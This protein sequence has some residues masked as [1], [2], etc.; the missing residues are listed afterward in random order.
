MCSILDESNVH[1]HHMWPFYNCQTTNMFE[2]IRLEF[3][4]N[5]ALCTL[6]YFFFI[7]VVKRIIILCGFPSC[8]ESRWARFIVVKVHWIWFY[9]LG[10]G[11]RTW[12]ELLTWFLIFCWHCVLFNIFLICSFRQISSNERWKGFFLGYFDN[13][14]NLFGVEEIGFLIM[15]SS[16]VIRR[17][18][19]LSNWIMLINCTRE[20][21]RK[22]VES[23]FRD[24]RYRSVLMFRFCG[25]ILWHIINGCCSYFRI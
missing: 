25:S 5:T 15:G 2:F 10:L 14:N 21:I 19:R 3:M 11:L 4:T 24:D 16:S 6:I 20:D 1:N 18:R 7:S 23:R 9:F 17:L 13:C 22:S 8:F 12:I